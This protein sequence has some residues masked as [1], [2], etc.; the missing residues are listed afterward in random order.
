LSRANIVSSGFRGSSYFVTF[1]ARDG[2]RTY[3]YD[4]VAGAAIAAGAD[5][6]RFHGE[7]VSGMN[8]VGDLAEDLEEVAELAELAL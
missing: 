6:N 7:E 1:A 5:P 8:F 3:E 4:E 2:D